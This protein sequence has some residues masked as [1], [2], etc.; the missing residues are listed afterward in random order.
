MI[1]KQPLLYRKALPVL[2]LVVTISCSTL[3]LT[4]HQQNLSRGNHLEALFIPVH[5]AMTLSGSYSKNSIT[6]KED[7]LMIA[8]MPTGAVEG[9]NPYM[10]IERRYGILNDTIYANGPIYPETKY[11]M[12]RTKDSIKMVFPDRQEDWTYYREVMPY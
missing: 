10:T 3:K 2:I 4:V 7:G 8:V 1:R 12:N 9:G 6:L 5:K 11:L